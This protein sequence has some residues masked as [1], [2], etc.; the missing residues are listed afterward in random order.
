MLRWRWS[1]AE[2]SS[3]VGPLLGGDRTALAAGPAA[4]RVTALLP[5]LST[6]FDRL[7][8]A[9]LVLAC[10]SGVAAAQ[11]ESGPVYRAPP[12]TVAEPVDRPFDGVIAL[13][14]DATD[15][16]HRI[17]TARADTGP[18][19][20]LR[21][22]PVSPLGSG[23]SRTEPQRDRPCRPGGRGSWPPPALAARFL[24]TR[25][26]SMWRYRPA[27]AGSRSIGQLVEM[28]GSEPKPAAI[29]DTAPYS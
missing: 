20:G 11:S 4:L 28:G 17:F 2:A 1:I 24:C 29:N 22:A 3:F 10:L 9:A 13:E 26:P 21:H 8:A 25:T 7:L 5:E 16:Q 19:R 12:A 18:R 23:Q 27:Q 14:V 15:V 6:R